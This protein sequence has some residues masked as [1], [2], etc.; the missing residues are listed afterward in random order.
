MGIEKGTFKDDLCEAGVRASSSCVMSEANTHKNIGE[1]NNKEI[2]H[3]LHN[4]CGG[5]MHAYTER[6]HG[7]T[8]CWRSG[9]SIADTN[10]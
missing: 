8:K 2:G 4:T 1:L 9:G 7:R 3:H 5:R 10:L 6:E